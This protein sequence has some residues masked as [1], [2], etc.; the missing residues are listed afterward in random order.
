MDASSQQRTMP[1]DRSGWNGEQIPSRRERETGV[2]LASPVAA[3]REQD[4]PLWSTSRSALLFIHAMMN[5]NNGGA[6]ATIRSISRVHYRPRR[7]A[8]LTRGLRMA[9]EVYH[10]LKGFSEE[11]D[12]GVGDEGGF[13]RTSRQPRSPLPYR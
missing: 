8:D 9:V 6:H 2:S 3:A 4:L 10:H 11:A 1:H 13:A 5:I 7:R 12:T